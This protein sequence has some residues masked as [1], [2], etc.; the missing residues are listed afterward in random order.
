[1]RS[2]WG[3]SGSMQSGDQVKSGLKTVYVNPVG[4]V[5]CRN[6]RVYKFVKLRFVPALDR[7]VGVVAPGMEIHNVPALPLS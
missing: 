6:D 3:F 5:Y 7:F 1:M 2:E 4:D